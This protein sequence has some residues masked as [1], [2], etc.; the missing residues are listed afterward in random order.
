MSKNQVIPGML[1]RTPAAGQF[2]AGFLM[3]CLT[4]HVGQ[5][6]GDLDPE[7]K[8]LNDQALET[9]EGR[10]FSSYDFPKADRGMEKLWIITDMNEDQT[11]NITTFLLP[12]DY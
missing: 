2:P 5:D 9:G 8:A 7:D 10:L 11:G 3:G 6:W 12:S 1:V 4:R